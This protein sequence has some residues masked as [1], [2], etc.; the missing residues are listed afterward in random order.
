CKVS[1][2]GIKS[3]SLCSHPAMRVVVSSSV[4]LELQSVLCEHR[5][6]DVR[7]GSDSLCGLLY[8]SSCSCDILR[9]RKEG[10]GGERSVPIYF[11]P[12]R[13]MI[14]FRSSRGAVQDGP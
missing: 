11:P 14:L 4:S 6:S 12:H 13:N 1:L 2:K 10:G 5:Q 9:W 3:T 8:S 7:R